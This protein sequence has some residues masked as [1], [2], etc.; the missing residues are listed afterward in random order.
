[1]TDR[2]QMLD[3]L[4]ESFA[5]VAAE[6]ERKSRRSTAFASGLL[7]FGSSGHTV[8]AA[9]GIAVLMGGTAYAVPATHTAFDNI[10]DSL[11]AWVSGDSDNAPGRAIEP[12]DNAPA[13]IADSDTSQPRLIAET[14]GVALFAIRTD[15]ARGPT[16][17]FSLGS[18]FGISNSLQGWRERL[19]Q[20]AVVI[21]GNAVFGDQRGGIDDQGRAPLFGVTNREVARVELQYADGAALEQPNGDGGFVLLVDAWRQPRNLIAYDR[22]GQIIERVV[23]SNIDLRYLC[24]KE[25]G[26]PPG[27]FS[28]GR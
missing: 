19:A 6:A 26:C 20:H 22:A 28:D 2:I 18:G 5:R 25:P 23:L 14:E 24:D 10:T 9:L 13:W 15:T 3:E 1:M 8:A 16:L 11:S 4:G 12:S 21:L 27:A 17:Q 7:R